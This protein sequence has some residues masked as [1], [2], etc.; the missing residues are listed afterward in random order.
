MGVIRY[1]FVQNKVLNVDF[2]QGIEYEA[3]DEV[4]K[5]L[6]FN[7]VEDFKYYFNYVLNSKPYIAKK[8]FLIF[9]AYYMK[10]GL[11][12]DGYYIK[13]FR[14][15]RY[16]IIRKSLKRYEKN[17]KQ[18]LIKYKILQNKKTKMN[19]IHRYKEEQK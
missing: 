17:K 12:K 18:N 16:N 3:L 1:G 15:N 8:V 5:I 4:K 2:W 19:K 13:F 7:S 14:T 11:L 9:D 10:K 6:K